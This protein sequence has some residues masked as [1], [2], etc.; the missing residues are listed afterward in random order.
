[1]YIEIPE[2]LYIK[3]QLY[4]KQKNSTP[5]KLAIKFIT[6]HIPVTDSSIGVCCNCGEKFVVTAKKKLYCCYD[7]YTT[8]PFPRLGISINEIRD[9]YG[10]SITEAAISLGVSRSQLSKVV[11]KYKLTGFNTRAI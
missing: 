4:A 2:K 8:S 7:C 6:E 1:M 5:D 9:C 10:I 3:L 11:K